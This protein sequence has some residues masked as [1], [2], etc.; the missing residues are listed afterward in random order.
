[1]WESEGAGEGEAGGRERALGS[2]PL[3]LNSICDLFLAVLGLS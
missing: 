2:R 1:M 3:F